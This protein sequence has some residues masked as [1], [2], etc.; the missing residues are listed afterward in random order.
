MLIVKTFI[1]I[2]C[3]KLFGFSTFLL[4]KIKL[5]VKEHFKFEKYKLFS[6]LLKILLPFKLMSYFKNVYF[7][8]S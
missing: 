1:S 3:L 5:A 2:I 7:K 6:K 8:N 4:N